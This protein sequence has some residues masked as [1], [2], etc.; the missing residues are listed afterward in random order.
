M[1]TSLASDIDLIEE[2]K[3]RRWAREHYVPQPKRDRAWH[4]IIHDEMGRKDRESRADGR[5]TPVAAA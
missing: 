5:G 4:P 1:G 2:L 3:L